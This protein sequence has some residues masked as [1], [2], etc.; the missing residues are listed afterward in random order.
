MIKSVKLTLE[1]FSVHYKILN[2]E[3][4]NN[5]LTKNLKKL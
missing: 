2:V 3:R 4:D 1:T 5:L